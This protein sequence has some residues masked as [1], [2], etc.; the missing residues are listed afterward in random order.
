MIPD[1]SSVVL[2]RT[3][4]AKKPFLFA[5][6]QLELPGLPHLKNLSFS[7]FW[8]TP[9]P[10]VDLPDEDWP[11]N[12]KLLSLSHMLLSG[13]V[14]R[15]IKE[16]WQHVA[17]LPLIC[18]D[19]SFTWWFICKSIHRFMMFNE[20]GPMKKLEGI[21]IFLLQEIIPLNDS[22]NMESFLLFK[23]KGIILSVFHQ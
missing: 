16:Q 3:Y 11:L 1:N 15:L 22:K 6:L 13:C 14:L 23:G 8:C 12:R 18:I 5:P 19:L 17:N 10:H 4:R 9:C 2:A 21:C 20:R 7:D